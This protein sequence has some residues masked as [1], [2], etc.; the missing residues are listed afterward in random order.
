MIM[1]RVEMEIARVNNGGNFLNKTEIQ[2]VFQ[3]KNS[4]SAIEVMLAWVEEQAGIL[5]SRG[6][7]II[8]LHMCPIWSDRLD[9]GGDL[10]SFSWNAK[11]GN[12]L[13]NELE[14]FQNNVEAKCE[15]EKS[16]GQR[17]M[18]YYGSQMSIG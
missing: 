7:S 17:G 3:A 9:V 16:F 4:G 15:E 10:R 14:R 12:D 8:G 2:Y 18:S 11:S 1:F 6:I 5:V 13:F